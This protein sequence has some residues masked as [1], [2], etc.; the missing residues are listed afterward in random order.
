LKIMVKVESTHFQGW[1]K[2]GSKWFTG[3]E[4]SRWGIEDIRNSSH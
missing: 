1:F 4:E 2:L 3:R